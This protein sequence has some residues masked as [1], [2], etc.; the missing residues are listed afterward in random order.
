M[1]LLVAAYLLFWD[2]WLIKHCSMWETAITSNS[3]LS[4]S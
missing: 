1:R 2:S 4:D 3:Y